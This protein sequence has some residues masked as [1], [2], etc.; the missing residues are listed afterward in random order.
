MKA[1]RAAGLLA[2][3]LLLSACVRIEAAAPP[4][5]TAPPPTPRPLDD[6]IVVEDD[7]NPIVGTEVVAAFPFLTNTDS[8]P[9]TFAVQANFYDVPKVSLGH[10]PAR[11]L[12][13]AGNVALTL[14]PG[15][16]KRVMI[17]ARNVASQ[18]IESVDYRL[19][20]K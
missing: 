18:P 10:D 2:I 12:V 14:Q 20:G 11:Y 8:V 9:R 5:P 3:I 13:T 15:E 6:V 17:Q 4:A 7:Q 19:I 16:L 1:I